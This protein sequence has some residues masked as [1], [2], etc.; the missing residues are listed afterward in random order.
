MTALAAVA[1]MVGCASVGVT[2]PSRGLRAAARVERPDA[3]VEYDVLVAELAQAEGRFEEARA[4]YG[5]AVAKDPDSA[6]L[7]E[8]LARLSWQLDDVD[9]AVREAERALA[10]DPEATRLRLFLGRLYNL[11]RDFEGLDRV[12]RDAEGEPL[13]ADAAFALHQVALER[14]DLDEAERLARKLMT[15][16]SDPMRGRLALVAVLELRQEYDR[17][18][19]VLREGL[20]QQPGNFLLSMRLAQLERARGDRA[21]ELAIY[22]SLLEQDPDHYGVLQRLGQAQVD[23]G[24]VAGAI[25]TYRRIV[26]AFPEDQSTLRRLASLEFATGQYAEATKRLEAVLE[27][28]PDDSELAL[29]VGQL[30]RAAGDDEDARA[31]FER[32]APG[33]PKYVEARLQIVG[34][35]ESRGELQEALDEVERLRAGGAGRPADLR[36]AALRAELGDA[37]GAKRLLTGMLDG[38]EGD[39]AVYYQLGLLEGGRARPEAALAAMRKVLEI[40]PQNAAALNYIGYAWAERGEKLGEAEKLIQ[41]ALTY[42]PDDG[43]ITDSLGW[44][45]FKMAE[46]ELA[47]G[48]QTEA[49]ALLDRAEAQLERAQTLSGGDPVISEHLGDVHLLRGE[50]AQALEAYEKAE[51]LGVREAEQPMLREK[52]ERLRRELGRGPASGGAP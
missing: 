38:S 1:A 41:Q 42:A 3:P 28:E 15:M 13:D 26:A 22:R 18:E 6:V 7:H 17:A 9:G 46:A 39:A 8:R 33:D 34:I 23:A 37:D 12:L 4:A 16:E 20:A 35:L 44:V 31:L 27:R 25:E 48:R 14:Q 52:L 47:E 10:L 2:P 49:E 19:A 45:Y 32:I 24:D 43:Y 5:R 36:A 40:D 50:K 29:V 51:G 21:G 11:R 30:R